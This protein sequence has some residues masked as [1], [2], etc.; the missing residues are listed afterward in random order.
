MVFG[1]PNNL[2]ISHVYNVAGCCQI[3]SAS[4]LAGR[5]KKVRSK[6]KTRYKMVMSCH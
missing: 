2:L 1:I 5:E 6:L 3:Q 4:G